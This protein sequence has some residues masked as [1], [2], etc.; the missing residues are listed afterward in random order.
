MS[1]PTKKTKD[2]ANREVSDVAKDAKSFIEKIL[3]DVSKT[4]ATKQ[5]VIGTTSGWWDEDVFE[6][7]LNH[8][9]SNSTFI[10]LLNLHVL[11]QLA[12]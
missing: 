9:T 1:L 5:I 6:S 2:D 4:S 10:Q 3:G 12:S 8:L 11:G 7:K